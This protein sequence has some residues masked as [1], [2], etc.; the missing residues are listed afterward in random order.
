M[1]KRENIPY[2]G[3][4]VP[5]Y[6]LEVRDAY[7]VNRGPRNGDSVGQKVEFLQ[8]AREQRAMNGLSVPNTVMSRKLEIRIILYTGTNI[9]N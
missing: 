3:S 2:V 6:I 7:S 4:I 1:I 5:G 8:F 9:F